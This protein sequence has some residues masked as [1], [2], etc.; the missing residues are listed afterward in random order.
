MTALWLALRAHFAWLLLAAGGVL[1]WLWLAA[2]SARDEARRDLAAETARADAAAASAERERQVLD[3]TLRAQA[4]HD[5][6]RAEIAATRVESEV[7]RTTAR[8][9]LTTSVDASGSTATEANR[10]MDERERAVTP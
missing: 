1:L 7:K 8:K 10:R 9:R 4:E 5:A 2:A 6:E 3:D